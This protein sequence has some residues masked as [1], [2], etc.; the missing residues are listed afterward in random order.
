MSGQL[1]VRVAAKFV[2]KVVIYASILA[3]SVLFTSFAVFWLLGFYENESAFLVLR[4][5]LIG[6]GAFMSICALRVLSRPYR[7]WRFS[8]PDTVF[9]G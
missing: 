6:E 1:S 5:A 2:L 7:S 4:G 8:Y 9:V 3:A